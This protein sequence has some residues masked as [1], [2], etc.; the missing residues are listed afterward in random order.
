MLISDYLSKKDILLRLVNIQSVISS[1][2]TSFELSAGKFAFIA[3][4]PN[5]PQYAA[6]F[7]SFETEIFELGLDFGNDYCD[8]QIYEVLQKL[9]SL[10]INAWQSFAKGMEMGKPF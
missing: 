8:G 3:L 4:G 5:E 6:E 2:F 10:G 1:K 9:D 7:R